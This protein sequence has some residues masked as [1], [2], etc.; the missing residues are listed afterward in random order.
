VG[1]AAE[2]GWPIAAS[3]DMLVVTSKLAGAAI[4]EKGIPWKID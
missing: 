2:T 4:G 3:D 1:K